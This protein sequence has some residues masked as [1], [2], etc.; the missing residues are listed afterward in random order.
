[1][2]TA[3]A[4]IVM[5]FSRSRSIES[6]I[7]STISRSVD[8]AGALQQAVGQRRLAVIDVGDDAEVA[9]PRLRDAIRHR[10]GRLIR[11]NRFGSR[12]NSDEYSGVAAND[13]EIAAVGGR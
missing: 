11:L 8:R 3:R 1:M 9:D 13:V 10:V 2:R 6:R 5:P 4:L 7:W 12:K